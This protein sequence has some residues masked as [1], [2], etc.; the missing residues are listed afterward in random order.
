MEFF[1]AQRLQNLP[2]YLFAE[3]DRRKRAAIAAGRDVIDFGVGDP[4]QPT[5]AYIRER[6]R[7]AIDDPANHRYPLGG[8]SPAF[9]RAIAAFFE[10]R[11]GVSLSPEREILALLGSKEGLGHLTLAVV[12]PGETVLIPDPGYPVYHSSTLFAGGTPHAMPLTESRAWLPELESIPASVA[13]AAKLMYLNY[14]NNPTGAMAPREFFER[15]VAFARKHEIILAHDAAYNDMY[16]D[17]GDRPLSVLQ[18]EGAKDVAVELHSLSKTF[19][20]TG[21][22]VGFAVGNADVLAALAKIKANLDSGVFG[23]IQESAIEAYAGMHRPELGEV[24]ALY[25][26]RAG[27][28]ADGLGELGFR[29]APPRATF[30]IWAGLPAGVRSMTG[31]ARLLDEADIVCV[32]GVGFGAGGDGFIRFAMTVD[33]DRT[34]AAVDRM[35]KL[36]W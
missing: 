27:I 34:R 10:R 26:Q 18:I 32:P 24:R 3:I 8:G 30:Y 36:Q 23:A 20:M 33:T 22:R 31:A 11:Y 29:V 35:R 2:P 21:W 6:M 12:N 1:P 9:R 17:E 7:R 14:P 19:N 4:E 13:R 16:F 28:M 5:Y 15:A 25:R